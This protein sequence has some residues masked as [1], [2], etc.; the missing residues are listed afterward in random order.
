MVPTILNNILKAMVF[1][2]VLDLS[3]SILGLGVMPVM[4]ES[5]NTLIRVLKFKFKICWICSI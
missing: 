2:H 5:L 4:K 3:L 1:N